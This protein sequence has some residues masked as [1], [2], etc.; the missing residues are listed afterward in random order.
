MYFL[1]CM[2]MMATNSGV[3]SFLAYLLKKLLK[4]NHSQVVCPKEVF[5]KECCIIEMSNVYLLVNL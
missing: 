2:T 1:Y 4:R 3:I 5:M